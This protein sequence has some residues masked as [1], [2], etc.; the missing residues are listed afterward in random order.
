MQHEYMINAYVREFVIT[1]GWHL[2]NVLLSQVSTPLNS[3][4]NIDYLAN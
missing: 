3:I 1:G 2:P 4:K